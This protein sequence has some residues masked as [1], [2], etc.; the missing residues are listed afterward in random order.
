V[1]NFRLLTNVDGATLNRIWLECHAI[2]L[3]YPLLMSCDRTKT[4]RV[5]GFSTT[6]S[7]PIFSFDLKCGPFDYEVEERESVHLTI[8]ING[9]VKPLVTGSAL[10]F[11][12]GT[13]LTLL[14]PYAEGSLD[15][16]DYDDILEVWRELPRRV[17]A[18]WGAP[19]APAPIYLP[20]DEALALIERRRL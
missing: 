5:R 9:G 20:R 13:L 11:A 1:T 18:R 16:K 8:P 6:G 4:G 3:E 12:D 19:A 14:A 7:M 10:H 15:V 17:I 2:L